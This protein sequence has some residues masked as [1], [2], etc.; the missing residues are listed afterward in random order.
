MKIMRVFIS[1]LM[2]GLIF[3]STFWISLGGVALSSLVLILLDRLHSSLM[4]TSVLCSIS[5]SVGQVLV[6]MTSLISLMPLVTAEKLMN[7]ALV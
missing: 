3:G 6:V 2:R 4:F 5:H 7:F 1:T